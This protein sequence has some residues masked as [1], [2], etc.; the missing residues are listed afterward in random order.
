MRKIFFTALVGAMMISCS[1]DNDDNGSVTNDTSILPTKI[2]YSE[3]YLKEAAVYTLSYNGNKLVKITDGRHDEIFTY[4]GDLITSI[5]YTDKKFFVFN[6]DSNGNLISEKYVNYDSDKIKTSEYNITY[7]INGS[8]VTAQSVAKYYSQSDEVLSIT[9]N[10]TYTLDEKKRPI[11]KVVVYEKKDIINNITY[12]GTNTFTFQYPNHHGFSEN[13]KGMDKLYYS[14][15]AFG[16]NRAKDLNY[17]VAYWVYLPF[18]YF[19]EEMYVTRLYPAGIPSPHG[20]ATDEGKIEYVVN[21]HNYPTRI[22][23]K[24]KSGSGEFESTINDGYY[25]IE[26][27]K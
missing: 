13:I 7:A 20:F 19:K 2:T 3:T 6:Y 16:I 24:F 4:T 8:T 11:K 15:F 17:P 25:T 1:R 18:S 14:Y 12:R 23:Y 27:N 9:S 21:A 10:I 5:N 22:K 26:Y